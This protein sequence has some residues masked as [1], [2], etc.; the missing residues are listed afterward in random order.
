MKLS[1]DA[2]EAFKSHVLFVYPEEA[3]GFVIDGAFVPIT[4]TAETPLTTFRIDPFEYLKASKSGEVQAVL[5]SHPYKIDDHRE[6]PPEWPS[7]AD[8]QS[9]MGGD[10]PW[11]IVATEG[12]GT[13]E[14]IWLDDSEIAPLEGREWVHG[15]TDCYAL[16]RDWFRVNR[17]VTLMN[18]ARNMEWWY[19]GQD[20]YSGNF[21]KAGFVEIPFHDATE[22]DLVLMQIRSP[23]VNHAAVIT[24]PNQIMH[25]LIK[26]LSGY[27]QLSK[28]ERIIVK[29]I[30]Y[31]GPQC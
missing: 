16:I 24:G 7:E 19:S 10:L 12:E 13:S 28:W 8:M 23:V 3:C 17:N 25:H 14:M 6:W 9:W 5:H 26:R 21:A 22:G 15:I 29:T 4:N 11:G 20:L 31:V 27:D 30:R 2:L 1:H 18:G